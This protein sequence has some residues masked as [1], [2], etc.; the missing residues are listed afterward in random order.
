MKIN[1]YDDMIC[2]LK[3]KLEPLIIDLLNAEKV[4]N[5]TKFNILATILLHT[6]NID[7]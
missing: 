1:Q 5:W 3:L 6:A 2:F 4:Q 7:N